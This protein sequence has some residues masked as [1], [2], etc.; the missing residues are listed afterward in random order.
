MAPDPHSTRAFSPV[1]SWT[2]TSFAGRILELTLA[3]PY[4]HL[5]LRVG[6]DITLRAARRVVGASCLICATSAALAVMPVARTFRDVLGLW[7]VA[8]LLGILAGLLVLMPFVRAMGGSLMAEA[9]ASDPRLTRLALDLEAHVL[10]Q[11][12]GPGTTTLSIEI[13]A[14]RPPRTFSLGGHDVRGRPTAQILLDDP[15][16]APTQEARA[17]LEHLMRT[18]LLSPGPYTPSWMEWT[19]ATVTLEITPD[20]SSAHTRLARADQR[21]TVGPDHIG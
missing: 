6:T 4:P 7:F 21:T 1:P 3:R 18:A 10:D 19:T 16:I 11:G 5:R 12:L 15:R 9:W 17:S 2:A 20:T 14:E 13:P 8:L